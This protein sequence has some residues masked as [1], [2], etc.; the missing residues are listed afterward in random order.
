LAWLL[1]SV[2]NALNQPENLITPAASVLFHFSHLLSAYLRRSCNSQL[3]Q[4]KAATNQS[5][6][7][8]QNSP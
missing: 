2:I 7:S 6:N 8:P 1:A 4:T 3:I 5:F